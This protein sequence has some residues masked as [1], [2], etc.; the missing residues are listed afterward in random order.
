MP[1]LLDSAW[2]A[3]FHLVDAFEEPRNPPATA[4]YRNSALADA[5]AV[6]AE[7]AQTQEKV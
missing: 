2:H 5:K 6:M 1:D 3:I 7:I 4:E